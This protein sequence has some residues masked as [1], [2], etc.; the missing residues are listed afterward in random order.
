MSTPL[1]T[2]KTAVPWGRLSAWPERCC[3]LFA[4]V[5]CLWPVAAA[6]A[7]RALDP[8][9]RLHLADHPGFPDAATRVVALLTALPGAAL[10][11]LGSWRLG[12]FFTASR[13]EA[14]QSLASVGLL[15]QAGQWLIGAGPAVFISRA[16]Q[17][18]LL[19]GAVKPFALPLMA[20]PVAAMVSGFG[21]VLL[22]FS[23]ALIYTLHLEEEVDSFV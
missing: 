9:L 8:V 15:H 5:F 6:A 17:S 13:R 10:L 14:K 3:G 11:A 12:Q 2:P 19:A 4:A 7:P 22:W 21:M 16:V 18:L 23:Q 20:L 1:T